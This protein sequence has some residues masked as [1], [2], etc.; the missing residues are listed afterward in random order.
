V[1]LFDALLLLALTFAV[2]GGLRVGLVAR[3]ATWLGIGIGILLATRSVPLVLGLAPETG[4]GMRLFVSV[5]TLTLTIT[6]VT[7]LFQS[8]GLS[9][10]RR[11]RATPLSGLDRV[12]G[13]AAGVA[14]VALVL[15]LLAPAAAVIPGEVARQVRGSTIAGVVAHLGPEPPDAVRSLRSLLDTTRFPEVLAGLQ[16]TPDTGPPP[17][18]IAVAPDVVEAVTASTS[19]VE[20][21]GC[22][23]SYEGSGF[24]VAGERVV[25]NAHVV[26]G[27]DEVAVRRP[28]GA[29]LDAVV[30]VFD[31]DR[32]LA[33][34]EVA[35][36]DQ[37]PLGL[38]ALERGDEAVVI[39][40]P[41]GQDVPRAAPARITDQRRAL[42]R[43]IYGREPTDRNVLFLAARLAQG[44]SGSPVVGID[45]RVGGVV[46]AISPDAPT[47]AYA[48]DLDE[49]Q[50]VLD[51]PR[52]PGEVGAC[53]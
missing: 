4:G 23:R 30:V 53:I 44:D 1:N 10:R 33:V 41:G 29:V 24:A 32:D 14:A 42:G 27:A 37:V 49:L 50:A 45:G 12:A 52:D 11:L 19:N 38:S 48:L 46:F 2:I 43:D 47:V 7:V 16:R 34:L 5:F 51:A 8:A 40:Y 21:H 15:W 26:A 36:L 35:G 3:A 9:L 25:T 17:D 13:A 20:A 18:Q 31:P 39:G 6:I 22:G 28:D